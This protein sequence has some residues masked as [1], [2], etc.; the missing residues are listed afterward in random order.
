MGQK[1]C[2]A[3]AQRT[4]A[5]PPPPKKK[6]TTL[7]IGL[8]QMQQGRGGGALLEGVGSKWGRGLRGLFLNEDKN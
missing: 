5:P 2:P 8:G 4:N 6:K 7:K 1:R 3:R